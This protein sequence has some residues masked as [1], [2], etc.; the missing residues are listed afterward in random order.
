MLEPIVAWAERRLKNAPTGNALED[1]VTLKAANYLRNLTSANCSNRVRQAVAKEDAAFD[2]RVFS[3][4][5]AS[6]LLNDSWWLSRPLVYR[7]SSNQGRS[8][9]DQNIWPAGIK[10]EITRVAIETLQSSDS[11][12]EL[13]AEA[14]MIVANGADL[15]VDARLQV[16]TAVNRRLMALCANPETLRARV[17]T[18]GEFAS[19]VTPDIKT[20]FG[21]Q[22]S[23]FQINDSNTA[24]LALVCLDVMKSLHDHAMVSQGL[25]DVLS[26]V[27]PSRDLLNMA[28]ETSKSDGGRNNGTSP[29]GPAS[30]L[31]LSWPD[32]TIVESGEV[33]GFNGRSVESLMVRKIL[34][35]PDPT[36][37]N[38]FDYCILQ[39]PVMQDY[40]ATIEK[41]ANNAQP[42]EAEKPAPM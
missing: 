20:P 40:L 19:F 39:H 15:D 11:P 25:S 29:F 3:T 38:W 2:N 6:S 7:N 28:Q 34:G 32:L 41:P 12:P 21:P 4:L 31:Q 17:T 23:I 10:S 42:A 24:Y 33:F 8:R 35:I 1:E 16:L 14:C 18:D 22:K 5:K 26:Q 30:G 27:Q 9:T 13:V 37:T 36:F